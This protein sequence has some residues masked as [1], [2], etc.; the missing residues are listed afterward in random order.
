MTDETTSGDEV[1]DA[2][3]L[4]IDLDGLEVVGQETMTPEPTGEDEEF[5]AL[6]GLYDATLRTIGTLRELP[7]RRAK[8][9][10]TLERLEVEERVWWIDQLIR[11]AL[12]GRS[13]EIDAMLA[14]SSWLIRLRLEDDY[15]SLQAMYIAAHEAERESI[16]FLLRD[17]PPHQALA[18][19]AR[20]Q[21]VRLPIPREVTLGER[22]S[23]ARGSDRR[24]LERLL[25]ENSPLVIEKLMQNPNIN[26]QDV[27]IVTTRRPTKPELLMPVVLT[28]KWFTDH[29]VRES[30]VQNPFAFT[31]VALKLMPTLHIDVLRKLKFAGDLHPT[32]GEAAKMLVELREQR[33]APWGY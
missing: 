28:D 30:V 12:W 27:M 29:R 24:L 25:Q 9:G 4:D 11:G 8:L 22:R 31:G 6:L 2:D 26:L 5:N 10:E 18:P 16:L 21:E 20:L 19:N 1:L 13:P 14:C 33:T 7:M 17:Y 23:L 15:D 3:E 32:I